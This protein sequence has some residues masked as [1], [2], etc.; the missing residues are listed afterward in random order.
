MI[1]KS[2]GILATFPKIATGTCS[3][4]LAVRGPA[5][6]QGLAQARAW[7]YPGTGTVAAG[8]DGTRGPGGCAASVAG[9]G[10]VQEELSAL[11]QGGRCQQRQRDAGLGSSLRPWEGDAGRAATAPGPRCHGG[12]CWGLLLCALPA[13]QCSGHGAG[14]GH[15]RRGRFWAESWALAKALA[16]VGGPGPGCVRVPQPGTAQGGCRSAVGPA[17]ALRPQ[18]GARTS[19]DGRCPKHRAP[20]PWGCSRPAW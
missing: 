20:S 10:A 6:P 16:G 9:L 18:S 13:L 2:K 1:S 4:C 12:V 3:W 15:S 11:V 14:D 5:R 19:S 7:G 8:S 17:R